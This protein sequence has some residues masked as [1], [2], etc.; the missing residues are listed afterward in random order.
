MRIWH[1]IKKEFF[2]LKR[3]KRMLF[4]TLVGVIIQLIVFG[5]VAS[6]DFKN[7][8]T[9]IIDFDRT[10]T[11]RQ[12]VNNLKNTGYFKIKNL[13]N[14]K[15][16]NHLI[17][18]GQ[19]K[20]VLYLPPD[21]TEKI[22][23]RQSGQIQAVFDGSDANTASIALG[24]LKGFIQQESQKIMEAIKARKISLPALPSVEL[25]IWY[26]PELKS[27]NY[28]VPG[29]IA[30]VMTMITIILTSVAIVR[31]KE[32]GTFDQLMVTPIE[33][34]ELLLGKI[35]PFVL[36]TFF[37]VLL[38]MAVGIFWFKVPLVGNIFLLFGLSLIF[39]TSSLGLGLLISAYSINQQQVLLTAMFI[40]FPS[41]MLGGFIF[42]VESMPKILQWVSAIIPM[43]YFLQIVRGI[44]LKGS[45]F[46]DLWPQVWPLLVISGVLF[47]LS[48][49]K[50]K[51]D[52]S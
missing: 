12:L 1:L 9:G 23:Q 51:K 48:V 36:V 8:S 41:M 15:E 39:L 35:L 46:S 42:P 37:D 20:M 21:F 22:F 27:V 29:T 32:Q 18:S 14:F 4:I 34:W 44:F 24:Y 6:F 40:I 13:N 52:I 11:S 38:V 28:M 19:I 2:Q 33:P 31:E 49:S 43:K 10:Q 16:A 47:V 25:R 30:F 50:L 3:D 7:I 5:Y 45:N 26:N 17:Q